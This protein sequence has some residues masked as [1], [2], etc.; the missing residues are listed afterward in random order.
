MTDTARHLLEDI[1]TRKPELL[2]KLSPGV[3]ETR[4]QWL[5]ICGDE[6]KLANERR[7]LMRREVIEFYKEKKREHALR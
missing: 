5:R 7:E 3:R 2:A 1:L 4:H 6:I